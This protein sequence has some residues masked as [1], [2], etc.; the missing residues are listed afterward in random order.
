M[1]HFLSSIVLALFVSCSVLE[2]LPTAVPIN[3]VCDKLTNYISALTNVVPLKMNFTEN[4]IGGDGIPH[5]AGTLEVSF[6]SPLKRVT[7]CYAVPLANLTA[8]QMSISGT[9]NITLP[10]LK[11]F[12]EKFNVKFHYLVKRLED[13]RVSANIT[14]AEVVSLASVKLGS[15]KDY[16]LEADEVIR[17]ALSIAFDKFSKESLTFVLD[18]NLSTKDETISALQLAMK[19]TILNFENGSKTVKT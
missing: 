1:Y 6:Y 4:S 16:T 19:E 18:D 7:N 2:A 13:G 11:L 12:I 8:V 3:D 17:P 9:L 10:E 15:G 14:L 5:P